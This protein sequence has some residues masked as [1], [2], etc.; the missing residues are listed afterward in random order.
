MKKRLGVIFLCFVWGLLLLPTTAMADDNHFSVSRIGEFVRTVKL[1]DTVTLSVNTRGDNLDGV[2]YTWEGPYGFI[3]TTEENSYTLEVAS[4]ADWGYYRCTAADVY[5]NESYVFFRVAAPENHFSATAEGGI[6]HKAAI[7]GSVTLSVNTRGDDLDGVTYTWEGPYGFICTT[8]EN[9]YTLE[10][11]SKADLG[12]YFCSAFDAYGNE[13]FIRFRVAA[14]NHF[15]AV[16]EGE[17][18]FE[19]S[20][21]DTVTLSVSVAGDDLDGVSYVWDGPYGFIC[22]TEENSYTLDILFKEDFGRY[23]C[24]VTDAYGNES[25]ICF[26]VAATENHFSATAEGGIDRKVTIG[27][28]VTLPVSV[29]G[30]NLKGVT[31]TWVGPRGFTWTTDESSCTLEIASWAD[32]GCYYC[33]AV[34]AYGNESE[35][36][37]R[38]AAENHFSAA[39]EGGIDHKVSIGDTVTLSV[40]T[41]GDDLK[42]VSYVWGGPSIIVCLENS[43]TLDVLFKEDFGRYHCIVSDAY[44]NESIV[45]FQVFAE[46]HFSV[47]PVGETKRTATIGD[48]VTLAV[49]A[50][51][52]DANDIWFSWFKLKQIDADGTRQFLEIDGA[53]TDTFTID[54]MSDEEAGTYKCVGYDGY[55]NK[56]AVEFTVTAEKP[57]NNDS[58]SNNASGSDNVAYPSVSAFSFTTNLSRINRVSVDG[59]AVASRYYTIINGVVTLSEEFMATLSNGNHTITAENATHMSTATFVVNNP[60]AQSPKTGDMGVVAYGLLSML[61]AAGIVTMYKK[62]EQK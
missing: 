56:S 32:L 9:S 30:D 22:T 20:I 53:E 34:D 51:A 13:S 16:A 17:T 52:D 27:S 18:E 19:V 21:G 24:T 60:T 54:K 58:P 3:C 41:A 49:E 33:T 2:T 44:G 31:Y 29:T 14:E 1:G 50:T 48:K 55:G 36:Y 28:S 47:V 35:I 42:G 40:K 43:Y 38:V 59:K 23:R 46:N 4:M 6:D 61:S 57:A 26:L 10:T 5:G 37:F 62:K 15:S 25:D 39:A 11:V 12:D 45:F 8:E 7:G